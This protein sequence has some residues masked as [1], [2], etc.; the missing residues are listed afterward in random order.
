MSIRVSRSLTLP[1]HFVLCVPFYFFFPGLLVSASLGERFLN[2]RP[3]RMQWVCGS[4]PLPSLSGD[5]RFSGSLASLGALGALARDQTPSH[6]RYRAAWILLHVQVRVMGRV[7]GLAAAVGDRAWR[8][9]MVGL[10]HSYC[11]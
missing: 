8:G 6:T 1:L 4:P 2:G 9:A 3:D 5:F 11:V 7:A 10:G